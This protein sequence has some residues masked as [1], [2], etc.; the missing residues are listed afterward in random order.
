[1][2]V[3]CRPTAPQL[4]YQSVEFK[5]V[6][7]QEIKAT[8]HGTISNDNL[9]PLSGKIAYATKLNGQTF[10]SGE[11]ETFSVGS[12]QTAPF[13]LDLSIN[14]P[15][16]YGSLKNLLE[17]LGAGE[18]E[19][20][21][22]LEGEYSTQTMLGFPLKAP[23]KAEG[24][25]PLPR[26]PKFSLTN[27]SVKS[28]SLTQMTVKISAQIVNNNDIPLNIQKFSYQLLGNN[29]AVVSSSFS[30]EMYILPNTTADVDWDLKVNLQSVDS[31]LV[32]RL[33]DGSL[34]TSLKQGFEQIQ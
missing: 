30:G 9:F 7:F 23:L 25:I 27:I 17:K 22:T 3:G 12:Q 28:L 34:Q 15:Q 26:L 32:K 8:V 5:P 11:T 10:F 31:T 1:M 19:L 16:V 21:F 14:L 24:K 20:P 13:A 29:S 6:S 33:L 2:L 18:T 4:A